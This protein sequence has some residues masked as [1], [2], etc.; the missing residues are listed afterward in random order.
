MLYVELLRKFSTIT[1]NSALLL[2]CLGG[3]D[4]WVVKD[5]QGYGVAI[6][7]VYNKEINEKAT[8]IKIFNAVKI[9]NNVE[10]NVILLMT[11]NNISREEFASICERFCEYGV[12]GK[13]RK[14]IINDPLSWWNRWKM[15]LG[16]R[17]Y[18]KAV[19]D[20]LGEL[21][22]YEK[23]LK[24]DENALWS[25]EKYGI[26]DITSGKGNYEVKST[27]S[28]YYN[29]VT[30]SSQHQ[31]NTT[32]TLYLVLCIFEPDGANPVSIN[33]VM[34]RLTVSKEKKELLEN[35]LTEY[36]YEKGSSSRNKKFT[37]I[38]MKKYAVDDDFPKITPQ[39]FVGGKLPVGVLKISYEISL[40]GINYTVMD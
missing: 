16:N 13:N 27:I 25:A 39:S 21:L 11:S 2:K 31:L 7:N 9:I 18:D 19:Y 6:E 8:G 28:R 4:T 12:D 17:I 29:K 15:L 5:S 40:D 36:G 32:D 22:V 37:L 34:T 35:K 24:I 33:E 14:N 10:R 20:V 3:H 38:E 1:F 26:V 30:I 23:I